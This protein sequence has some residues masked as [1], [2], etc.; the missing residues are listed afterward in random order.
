LTLSFGHITKRQIG[1]PNITKESNIY[2]NLLQAPHETTPHKNIFSDLL[3]EDTRL[4][5][6]GK[7]I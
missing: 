7:F 4:Q 3:N 5:N 6:F 2:L 1:L